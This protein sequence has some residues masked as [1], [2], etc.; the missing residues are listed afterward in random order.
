MTDSTNAA[1]AGAQSSGTSSVTTPTYTVTV[2]GTAAQPGGDQ[3]K[4]AE[5]LKQA[6]EWRTRFTGLQGKYQQEQK[7]WADDA[8]RV[9]EL[10]DILAKVT[11]EKEAL[12]LSISELTEKADTA[13]TEAALAQS[14]LERIKMVTVEFPDLVPFLGDELLPDGTGDEL[15][16]KLKLFSG[17]IEGIKKD[18]ITDI[19]RGSSPSD[20]PKPQDKSSQ[21]LLQQA[22][23]EFRKGNTAGYNDLYQQ[24]MNS[25]GG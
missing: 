25:L 22:I 21:A 15:R 24:Y 10:G 19:A 8:A 16:E 13:A 2:D 4:L 23:E 17:K 3:A 14:Q 12:G 18:K 7:K 11:G 6:E 5:A 20:T 9:M 1:D